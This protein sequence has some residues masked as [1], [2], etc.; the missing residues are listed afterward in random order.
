MKLN[1]MMKR[2]SLLPQGLRYKLL[3]AFSLMSII[4][5]LVIGYLVNNFAVLGEVPSLGQISI[6]ALFSIVVAW[7]GLFLAKSII[8]RVIEVAIATKIITEGNFDRKIATD[9]G[10]EIGQLGES[11]NFLTRKIRDNMSDLKDYQS[12]MKEINLDIQKR[13]SVL[14][15]LL[16]IGELISSSVKLDSIIE[17]VLSKVSQLYEKGFAALYFS[18]NPEDDLALQAASNVESK[19]L[20]TATIKKGK[21]FLGIAMQKGKYGLM[22]ASSKLS[23]GDQDF[24][25]KCKC[26]SLIA[27]PLIITRDARA[28]LLIGN[29]VKN[30]TYTN[31]DVEVIKVFAEQIAIAIENDILVR[32]A[33]RLEIKDELTGLF[34]KPYVV[35]RLKEEIQRSI[36]SQRPCA[37]ILIDIDDYRAYSRQRGDAQ[38]E[39]ALKR[40]AEFVSKFAG[41]VCKVGRM[42]SDTLALLMPESNK[43]DALEIAE[44]IRSGINALKLSSEAADRLTACCGVSENPLDGS[45]AAAILEKAEIA[46]KR[47]KEAE[48]NKVIAAGV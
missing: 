39:L 2:F 47:A 24:K 15:N 7:M 42:E 16:Q 19:E 18:D 5:L 22:D 41:P 12:K 44:K 33:K 20:L 45:T 3:I 43:K 23:A 17:L 26:E 14:A 21:G 8:E 27:F 48:K 4:P 13:I 37:F 25:A 35:S 31:D 38:A 29:S 30:F 40:I 32:R 1:D 36:I 9:T 11:I 46:L 10:D 34:N 6:I 28:L